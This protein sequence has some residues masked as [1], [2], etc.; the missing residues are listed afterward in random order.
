MHGPQRLRYMRRAYFETRYVDQEPSATRLG[1]ARNNKLIF[2]AN[3]QA[4]CD[5]APRVL[6]VDT[7]ACSCFSDCDQV[8]VKLQ[9]AHA[10]S[11]LACFL[12]SESSSPFQKCQ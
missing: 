2:R 1:A 10:P 8:S 9:L 7:C 5:Q 3:A 6:F 11:S 12:A 4:H